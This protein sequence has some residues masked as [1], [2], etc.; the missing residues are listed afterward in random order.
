MEGRKG[1]GEQKLRRR[2][3]ANRLL[4]VLRY[5]VQAKSN[6]YELKTFFKTPKY[7]FPT[8]KEMIRGKESF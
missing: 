4:Y 5:N 7:V 2:K 6:I 8:L 3:S 1:Q